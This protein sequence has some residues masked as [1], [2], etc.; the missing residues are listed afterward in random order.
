MKYAFEDE[1]CA[2][3]S[4]MQTFMGLTQAKDSG[5][6]SHIPLEPVV[7]VVRA[8]SQKYVLLKRHVAP[9]GTERNSSK[10]SV[11]FIALA[12]LAKL[13]RSL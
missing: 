1:G 8:P 9:K 5:L 2:S 4:S 6:K 11:N 3:I 13:R 12:K 7:H 10:S